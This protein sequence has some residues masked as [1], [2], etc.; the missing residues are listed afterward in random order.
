MVP[1]KKATLWRGDDL[2]S[3]I[4]EVTGKTWLCCL[5]WAPRIQEGAKRRSRKFTVARQ[6]L[7][8]NMS[9][10]YVTMRRNINTAP[11]HLRN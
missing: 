3:R 9:I 11:S 5:V 2:A 1:E 6:V 4:G 8:D 10:S 7:N